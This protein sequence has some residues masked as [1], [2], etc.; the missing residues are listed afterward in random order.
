MGVNSGVG[1][2]AGDQQPEAGDQ[3]S[4]I[5]VQDLTVIKQVLDTAAI[6]HAPPIATPPEKDP[7]EA[8]PSVTPTSDPQLTT[9][10]S[11]APPE[12]PQSAI[13]NPQL[14][15]GLAPEAWRNQGHNFRF[16]VAN[17]ILFSV[18]EA[19]YAPTVVLPWFINNLGGSNALIG[20]LP[21]IINGGWFLPQLF[22]ASRI[23]HLPR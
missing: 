9:P 10:S 2:G 11:S 23:Q 17:G 7:T 1:A 18:A 21:A 12:I 20:V 4:E 13:R 5:R 22:I 6:E 16:G 15:E 3:T 14:I 8:P 19:F